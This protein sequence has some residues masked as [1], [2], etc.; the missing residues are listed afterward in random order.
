MGCNFGVLAADK[1]KKVNKMILISPEFGEYSSEE[2]KQIKYEKIHPNIQTAYGENQP[3]INSNMLKSLILFKKSKQLATTTIEKINI[4]ILIIY[5]KDD[6][7]IPKDYLNDLEARKENIKIATID[8]K[9]HNPL[10]SQ[11]HNQTTMRL[12][13]NYLK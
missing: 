10:I 12:I 2:K 4:P 3:Q 6:T 8:T 9:L 5:S 7:F 13:K 1:S 11:T